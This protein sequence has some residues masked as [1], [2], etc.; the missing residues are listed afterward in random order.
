MT[1]ETGCRGGRVV[2]GVCA[3]GW[4]GV[5]VTTG[6]RTDPLRFVVWARAGDHKNTIN[7]RG[8]DLVFIARL[9]GS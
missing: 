6:L 4:D 7:N 2:A 3:A 9:I 8:I 5:V 1:S